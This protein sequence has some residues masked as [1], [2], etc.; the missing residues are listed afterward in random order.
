MWNFCPCILYVSLETK[1]LSKIEIFSWLV[2]LI[3][4]KRVAAVKVVF[5]TILVNSKSLFFPLVLI[6]KVLAVANVCKISDV[7]GIF[8]TGGVWV[9]CW[10]EGE[11]LYLINDLSEGGTS[12]SLR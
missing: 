12:L 7:E 4:S 2:L 1:N 6:V 10:A 8:Y 5:F 3:L 11:W 9:V